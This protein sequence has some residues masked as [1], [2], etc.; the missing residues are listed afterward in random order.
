MV[1]CVSPF[2]ENN[3]IG[4]NVCGV[5]YERSEDAASVQNRSL[6]SLDKPFL[7]SARNLLTPRY[8]AIEDTALYITGQSFAVDGGMAIGA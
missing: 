8:L 4:S 7:C 5:V 2:S 6:N 3:F 1:A